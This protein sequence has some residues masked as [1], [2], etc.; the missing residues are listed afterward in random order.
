M[1]S[2]ASGWRPLLAFSLAIASIQVALACSSDDGTPTP[3][4]DGGA[5]DDA[6]R[7]EASDDNAPR[8]Q[9][10]A[11]A[12]CAFY[13]KCD[14]IYLKVIYGDIAT[15]RTR[16]L[17]S[18]TDSLS[19][20]GNV[21]SSSQ[22]TAC[23]NKLGATSCDDHL[24]SLPECDFRGTLE[25]GA[26]C[27]YSGQCKGGS[28]LPRSV[29][30]GFAACGT[31]STRLVEGGDCTRGECRPGFACAE[32][33]CA[34][35]GSAGEPCDAAKPCR[36]DLH[37]A[38]DGKCAAR[39]GPG[40]PCNPSAPSPCDVARG[41]NCIEE[42]ATTGTCKENAY[43]ILGG[44]CGF[45]ATARIFTSCLRSYC[46]TG[47]GTDRTCTTRKAADA[48][49]LNDDECTD[50]HYCENGVCRPANATVCK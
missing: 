17:V 33:R 30:G 40:A 28:C 8:P 31:C 12:L 25:D 50:A 48:P 35:K 27:A 5:L 43:A 39:L 21:V 18:T 1:M 4:G 22:L 24:F 6:S 46:S 11:D 37:C 3:R 42:T 7:A 38:A 45:D 41:L 36:T 26:P 23:A 15:C 44:K 47:V 2:F 14:P 13:E 29:D 34:K 16:L 19:A 9:V 10:Y 32:A 49:C 20:P